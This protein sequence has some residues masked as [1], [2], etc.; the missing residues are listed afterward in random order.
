VT[1][2]QPQRFGAGLYRRWAQFF[3]PPGRTRRLAIHASDLVAG[4]DQRL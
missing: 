3:T 4:C 1:H 2:H